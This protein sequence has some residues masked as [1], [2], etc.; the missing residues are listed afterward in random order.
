MARKYPDRL[1]TNETMNTGESL[2]SPHGTTTLVLQPDGNL[3]LYKLPERKA[4]WASGTMGQKVGSAAM[5]W[6]GWL[7]LHEGPNGTGKIV[8]Q[9]GSG[10]SKNSMAVVQDDGNLVG[11]RNHSGNYGNDAIWAT[12]TDKFQVKSLNGKLG[13][14]RHEKGDFLSNAVKS[15]GREIGTVTHAIQ[16][17]EGKI[18]HEIAKIPIVGAPLHSLFDA[19]FMGVVGPSTILVSV[20][21]DGQALDKAFMAQVNKEIAIFKDVGPY[22]Q[23]VVSFIPGIGTAISAA[24]GV[25]LAL[26]NGQPIDQVLIA[27]VAGALPGGPLAKAALTMADQGIRAA[28]EHTKF[29]LTMLAKTAAG[30]ASDVLNLPAAAKDAILAGVNMAGQ[31]VHGVKIETALV[32]SAVSA[33]PVGSEVKSALS[34]VSSIAL[35]LSHGARIDKTILAHATD[36]VG[37][38]P[39]DA[40]LKATILG[41]TKTGKALVTGHPEAALQSALQTATSEGLINIGGDKLPKDVRQAITTG[42]AVSTGV[43]HQAAKVVA[44]NPTVVN[45]LVQSGIQAA[46]TNPVVQQARTL[47][48]DGAK[49]FD[50]ASGLLSQHATMFDVVH[51]RNTMQGGDK[52]GFDAAMALRVGLVAHPP[53]VTL[54]PPAQAGHAITLG[55]QG[56]PADN[57]QAI[58]ATLVAHPSASVGA[59]VAVK[60]VAIAREFWL[61]RLLRALHL[62][63]T[64]AAPSGVPIPKVP[65]KAA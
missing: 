57:K 48:K 62:L 36:A 7:R 45:K 46:K 5:T 15:A 41:A 33:L 26:A 30:A 39:I 18:S 4:L 14:V 24:I 29:D 1:W 60:Q 42:I 31:L 53:A 52:K 58:M 9:A 10:G 21:I 44:I 59:A 56:A 34:T 63:P 23:M 6:D 51:L 11:F 3:V 22:A 16:D 43:V 8:W 28:I 50:A 37:V 38:L 19:G 32:M 40:K 54:S 13:Y 35:D 12:T 65:Q 49:G 25:G 27:G 17:F 47:V 61:T 2:T 20:V 64:P 55:M